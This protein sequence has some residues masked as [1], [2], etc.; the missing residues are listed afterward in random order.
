MYC[1]CRRLTRA[2]TLVEIMVVI[3]IIGLLATAV[4]INVRN[5]LTRAKQNAA[6]QDIVTI[7]NAIDIFWSDYSRYPTNEEGLDILTQPTSKIPEGLLEHIPNDPWGH[8]YQYISPGATKPY[9]IICLGA[10]G[11][12]GGEGG[13]A[14]ITS[15]SVRK[16]E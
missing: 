16:R 7:A 8:P 15:E 13:D 1:K 11:R 10:D 14:D 2:F 9:D 6:K 4:T 3:V 5:Y 12:E